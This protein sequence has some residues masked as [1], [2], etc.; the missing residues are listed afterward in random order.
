MV[1]QGP[2]PGQGAQLTCPEILFH[3]KCPQQAALLSP[4][5]KRVSSQ[6]AQA[7]T[8]MFCLPHVITGDTFFPSL[9]RQ[10]PF[11]NICLWMEQEK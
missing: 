8:A 11:V 10:D 9:K 2:A 3:E 7:A 5:A 6:A 1:G 4:C